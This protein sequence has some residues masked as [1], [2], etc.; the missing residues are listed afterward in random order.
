MPAALDSTIRGRDP[1]L[2]LLGE[3]LDRVRSGSGAVVLIEGA[4]GMGKSRLIG[5]AMRMAR[6]LSLPVG[7]GVAEPSERVA[8]LAP[9]LRALFDGPEP[10]LD[11]G[12]L[13][14][15]H[16]VPEQR[17]WL[18]QDLQSL[19]ERAAMDRPLLICLDD[20]QW[21]DSGT[22]AAL[23][24]LPPRLVSLPI[25]WVLAM[26]PDQGPAQLQSAVEQLARDGARLVLEPLSQAAVAQVATDVVQAK[27]DQALLRMAEDAGG[28]PFLLVELLLGLRQEQLLRIDSGEAT[29][30]ATRLPD[31]FR[32]SMR[33]RLARMPESARQVAT[34]AA[35]LGRTFSFSDLATM[36]RLPPA[37]L[38]TPVEQLIDASILR[39]D[40]DQLSFRHDLT[41]EAV[42]HAAALSARRALDRQAADVLMAGGALPVEVATQLAASAEPGDERAIATLRDAAETLGTSDPSA[43]AGLSRRALELAPRKHPLRGALVAQ[44]TVLLH[45]A[46]RPEEAQAFAEEY[47]Q[48]VLPTAEE[49][50]VC[51]SIANMFA[52][53][54]DIRAAAS[55]RAL[56]LP[57]LSTRDRARHLARLVYNL[58]QAGRPGEAQS[59]LAD[60]RTVIGS[61]EDATAASILKLAEGE[62]LYIEGH[63][64]RSLQVH[65]AAMRRGFGPGETTQESGASH[66]RSEL[67]AVLDRLDESMRLIS[68]SI[69]SA[70]R[71]RQGWK[72]D[73]LETWRGRQLFQRGRLSDAAA[74]L[75]GRFDP[76]EAHKVGGALH[77]A[78]VIALGRVAIHTDD[79][80][81]KRETADVAK[82]MLETG[83]PANQRH[84]AWLLALQAMADLDPTRALAWLSAPEAADNPLIVPLYPMDVTDE[85][86]LVRIALAGGDRQL[87]A[88]A[89]AIAERR[90]QRSPNVGSVK[91]AAA[92]TRGL[93]DDDTAQLAKAAELFHRERPL[94]LASALED[95]GSSHLRRQ[96][97][98]PGVEALGRALVLYADAGA[99][100]DVR[101]VRGRLRA[102]GVRRRL[103]ATERPEKGWAALT[104]SELAVVRL[105][106]EGL[107]N[108]DAAERL[109]VS[110]HTVNSHLR[111]AFTKLGVNSR[112]ELTRHV[113]QENRQP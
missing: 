52:L 71:D 53:S 54:P 29:L 69:A 61:A 44:T 92:H 45:A 87:A 22:V 104:E 70:H 80:R 49:A 85:P 66:W 59:L 102:Q 18:L 81:R 101:R 98:Q 107:T 33:E 8:E 111:H 2:G 9:L 4:A 37:S 41:R 5:E 82:V 94:A 60:A 15:L 7:T 48:K 34:V 93:L 56:V 88:Q 13:S 43:A 40:G 42:R 99:T 86:Q 12:A 55:R 100:W 103:V 105:V 28:N 73:F 47:L 11:R 46:A 17:Y 95:L 20:L 32:T 50:E 25:G 1:E 23:R 65:E 57:G 58:I 96:A 68:E 51:L 78:G 112:V 39:E 77:A 72:L 63:F 38:L 90:T 89:V 76:E 21:A 74:A 14:S 109:F 113:G 108:R 26:R 110:P 91:A 36:L 19:L 10:L 67:L 106:A 31:R 3:Q 16:A 84:G 75:E 24:A 83:T 62:L 27:P 64:D 97:R 35:S 6:R 30:T 79:E